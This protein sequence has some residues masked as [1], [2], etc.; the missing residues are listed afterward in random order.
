MSPANNDEATEVITNAKEL[1]MS[2]DRRVCL[3]LERFTRV[4]NARA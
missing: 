2:E 1:M 4:K 3:G